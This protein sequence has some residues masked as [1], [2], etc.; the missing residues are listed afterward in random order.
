[1]SSTDSKQ[2]R[3]P[4]PRVPF[5]L[6]LNPELRERLACAAAERGQ[7]AADVVRAALAG[8]LD[9]EAARLP[10]IPANLSARISHRAQRSG[11]SSQAIV[12]E[13]LRQYLDDDLLTAELVHQNREDEDDRP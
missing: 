6:H 13:A 3:T 7:P 10:G 2:P 9:G 1:M 11:R 8:Y 4:E 12:V 5:T